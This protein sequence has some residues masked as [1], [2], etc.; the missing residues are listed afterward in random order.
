[1]N[2]L[3]ISGL[4]IIAATSLA[5]GAESDFPEIKKLEN[6]QLQNRSQA[7]DNQI[8]TQEKNFAQNKEKQADQYMKDNTSA[9]SQKQKTQ[10][11]APL[12][13]KQNSDGNANQKYIK[14]K[15]LT[16]TLAKNK[17]KQINKHMKNNSSGV[18][19]KLKTQNNSDFIKELNLT[20]KQIKKI[21]NLRK[22]N[23]AERK[24]L[25]RKIQ[26]QEKMLKNE[27]SKQ[28]PDKK[29]IEKITKEIKQLQNKKIDNRINAFLSMKKTLNNK[30]FNKMQKMNAKN[31]QSQRAS[32]RLGAS[33]MRNLIKNSSG[34]QGSDSSQGR[35]RK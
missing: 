5:Y 17:E 28:S 34:A 35:G 14:T 21:E 31:T 12:T 7:L 29:K 10:N 11:N 4:V 19:Q 22:A 8:K 30:Q 26:K 20:K 25:Q 6:T 16:K 13:K 24:E 32:H 2:K 23:I 27:F 3:L 33:Q 18:N 9:M 15:T 1:M